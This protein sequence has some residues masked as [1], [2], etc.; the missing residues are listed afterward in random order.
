MNNPTSKENAGART[1]FEKYLFM[2]L[3]SRWFATVGYEWAIQFNRY[4]L[5]PIGLWPVDYR[6]KRRFFASARAVMCF[7]LILSV[8][9]IPCICSL[10]VYHHNIMVVINNLTYVVPLIITHL[11][12]FIVFKHKQCKFAYQILCIFIIPTFETVCT[13]IINYFTFLSSF[14]DC[15][16]D[17]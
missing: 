10:I 17:G 1:L 15:K 7:T 2:Y 4:F 13:Y 16:Y 8:F 9:T 5:D 14:V 6:G 3:I 12:L 11:K